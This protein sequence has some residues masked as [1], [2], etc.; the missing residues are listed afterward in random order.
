MED[1]DDDD[2]DDALSFT[3][4]PL[5]SSVQRWNIAPLT[6]KTRTFVVFLRLMRKHMSKAKLI[7]L[8]FHDVF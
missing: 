1:D 4:L 5:K 8:H 7:D 6:L 2:D 3:I